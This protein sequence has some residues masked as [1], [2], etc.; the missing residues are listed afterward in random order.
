MAIL[1][2][3]SSPEPPNPHTLLQPFSSSIF[4]M[5]VP[6]LCCQHP[7]L[8]SASNS[9]P[10]HS[11]S[12]PT[13]SL[14]S[15]TLLFLA[16]CT[17]F[18]STCGETHLTVFRRPPA[19]PTLIPSEHLHPSQGLHLL[20]FVLHLCFSLS[21]PFQHLLLLLLQII[22]RICLLSLNDL[23]QNWHSR[24][25]YCIYR[26]VNVACTKQRPYLPLPDALGVWVLCCSTLCLSAHCCCSHFCS[27]AFLLIV[28]SMTAVAASDVP[29]ILAFSAFALFTCFHLHHLSSSLLFL[30]L[31]SLFCLHLCYPLFE[32]FHFFFFCH[33]HCRCCSRSWSTSLNDIAL[34]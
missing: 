19:P 23:C 1:P 17:S 20:L 31:S 7:S 10:Q 18:S 6:L 3:I 9:F 13:S 16:M 34:Q 2:W 8:S 26:I 5:E 11:S 14:P 33:F 4:S 15:A 25:T 32:L 27:S 12:P 30:L 29:I 21:L 22:S 24:H 28:C